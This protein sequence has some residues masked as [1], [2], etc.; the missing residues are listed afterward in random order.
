[1]NINYKMSSAA[2]VVLESYLYYLFICIY[3]LKDSVLKKKIPNRIMFCF[4][5]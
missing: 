4:I 1:M 5:V 2:I 3:F